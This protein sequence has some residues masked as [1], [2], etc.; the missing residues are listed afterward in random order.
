M[1]SLL[2][3]SKKDRQNVRVYK[4][5]K[6]AEH[7]LIAIWNYTFDQWGETQADDYL[8]TIQSAIRLLV[9][10]PQMGKSREALRMAYRSHYQNKH[11]IFYRPTHYGIRVVRILHQSMDSERHLP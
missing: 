9:E 5:S 2:L 11:V 6:K 10:N 3:K 8:Q 7:D 4:L 1:R